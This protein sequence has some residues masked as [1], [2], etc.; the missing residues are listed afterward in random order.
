[1]KNEAGMDPWQRRFEV[2]IIP[3]DAL[4]A[5]LTL[6]LSSTKLITDS[7]LPAPSQRC[8][9]VFKSID[10]VYRGLI[11]SATSLFRASY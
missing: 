11:L 5:L 8:H 10:L 3:I 4:R 1:M 6:L 2:G 7:L 9:N